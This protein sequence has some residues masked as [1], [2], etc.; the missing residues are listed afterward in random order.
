[1]VPYYSE[2][3]SSESTVGRTKV[4]RNPAGI[5]VRR[6]T[7]NK[8]VQ[9]TKGIAGSCDTDIWPRGGNSLSNDSGNDNNNVIRKIYNK[10]SAGNTVSRIETHCC[11]SAQCVRCGMYCIHTL[12]VRVP[13]GDFY[14]TAVLV[15]ASW[16]LYSY[17]NQNDTGQTNVCLFLSALVCQLGNG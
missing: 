10:Q 12:G 1:M 5:I 14:S 4:V 6:Y 16:T 15:F 9:G 3:L 13:R 2:D 11:C 8:G 7:V 17:V